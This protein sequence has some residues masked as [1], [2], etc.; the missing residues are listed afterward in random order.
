[1]RP[2]ALRSVTPFPRPT[3]ISALDHHP[4]TRVPD[5]PSMDRESVI[6]EPNE[7]VAIFISWLY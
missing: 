3:L 1:M 4:L 6:S 5:N 2:I 7:F